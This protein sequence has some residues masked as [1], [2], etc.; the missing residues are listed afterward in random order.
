[1]GPVPRSPYAALKRLGGLTGPVQISRG[2]L[3]IG[4]KKMNNSSMN[5]QTRPA[6]KPS[7]ALPDDSSPDFV[8]KTEEKGVPLKPAD[9]TSKSVAPNDYANTQE[10]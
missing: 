6:V 3:N 10:G 9:S 8:I 4:E 5:A 2:S 1:M 7:V